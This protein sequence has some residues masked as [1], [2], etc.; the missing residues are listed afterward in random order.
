MMIKFINKN[1][2]TPVDPDVIRFDEDGSVGIFYQ[3]Q[4]F[5]LSDEPEILAT[6]PTADGVFFIYDLDRYS[7]GGTIDDIRVRGKKLIGDRLGESGWYIYN[8]NIGAKSDVAGAYTEQLSIGGQ[9]V[10]IRCEMYG[11]REENGI[12]LHNQGVDL[13]KDIVRAFYD[14]DIH[15]M[16]VDWIVLNRK[17]KELILE[18]ADIIYNKGSYA[19]LIN[20]LRWFEYGDMLKIYEFWS[21]PD[22]ITLHRKELNLEWNDT[23][24]SLAEIY[25]KT[26]YISLALDTMKEKTDGEGNIIYEIEDGECAYPVLE[27]IL[28]KWTIDDLMLKMTLM[29]NYFSTFFMPIHLDLLYSSIER[30]ICATPGKGKTHHGPGMYGAEV[31]DKDEYIS[32][33]GLYDEY[34][35]GDVMVSATASTP[36]MSK[37]KAFGVQ[38]LSDI[39]NDHTYEDNN[40]GTGVFSDATRAGLRIGAYAVI[41]IRIGVSVHEGAQH[42]E[43]IFTTLIARVGD[44]IIESP[45]AL[46]T[47]GEM[48]NINIYIATGG[49]YTIGL[50]LIGDNGICLSRAFS[51]KVLPPE[52]NHF[53][54]KIMR[55]WLPDP[56]DITTG[57]IDGN[58]PSLAFGSDDETYDMKYP[59]EICHGMLIFTYIPDPSRP[60]QIYFEYGPE[61]ADD[62][63]GLATSFPDVMHLEAD[64]NSKGIY[65]TFWKENADGSTTVYLILREPGKG[66]RSHVYAGGDSFKDMRFVRFLWEDDPDG[67]MRD[68]GRDRCVMLIP[69]DILVEGGTGWVWKVRCERDGVTGDIRSQ[70]M[71]MVWCCNDSEYRPGI[72]TSSLN[73]RYPGVEVSHVRRNIYRIS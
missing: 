18:A 62:I 68:V 5:F 70:A 33:D 13:P 39:D 71:P 48:M 17:Y 60:E 30:K 16:N 72:Y 56:K 24:R 66:S 19:S 58:I 53:D 23:V 69:Q 22:M 2:G 7:P 20:S 63:A 54:A 3:K 43:R 8:I 1:T 25:M 59:D 10:N 57:T 35:I 46:R 38:V 64:M 52:S 27:D 9:K 29:G 41:P 67:D 65:Y 36:L 4:L 6:V 31:I 26:T 21:T 50:N 15:D 73:V 42:R 55:H 47:G 37:S 11:E 32:I 34:V 40:P 51:I 45:V 49:D 12:L 14:T 28:V 61:F 44:E